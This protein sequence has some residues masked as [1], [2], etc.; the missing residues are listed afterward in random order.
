MSQII[1]QLSCLL[2]H[3]SQ[4]IY[5]QHPVA[6]HFTFLTTLPQRNQKSF[7]SCKKSK[8]F[9]FATASRR[10]STLTVQ[11]F[12]ASVAADAF[13]TSSPGTERILSPIRNVTSLISDLV[14]QHDSKPIVIGYAKFT[15][16]RQFSGKDSAELA[17]SSV[18]TNEKNPHPNSN[19]Y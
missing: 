4:Q 9:S 13:P 19:E 10:W 12:F 6:Q 1:T 15:T 17:S 16:C 8:V 2:L 18:Y 11:E 5:Q 3:S 14:F 7:R